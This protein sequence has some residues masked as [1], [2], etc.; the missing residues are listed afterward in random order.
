M[1]FPSLLILLLLGS[2]PMEAAAEGVPDALRKAW[3][4]RQDL[5]KTARF[6]WQSTCDERPA[7]TPQ[8][9]AN[10]STVPDLVTIRLPGVFMLDGKKCRYSTSQINLR[11]VA[12]PTEGEY[13]STFN[14]RQ[15]RHLFSGKAKSIN[16]GVV[17]SA[18]K[19]NDMGNI[20]FR[21]L[22]LCLRGL[23]ANFHGSA[24]FLSSLEVVS[25]EQV[26][27]GRQCNLLR[28]K[29]ER[30]QQDVV[31]SLAVDPAREY[32]VVQ[33]AVQVK[34]R[35]SSQ[36]DITYREDPIVGW[37][38][39]GWHVIRL[40]RNGVVASRAKSVVSDY[41]LNEPLSDELFTIEFSPGTY[42]E[43]RASGTKYLLR[44][45]G[46]QRPILAVESRRGATWEQLMATEPGKAGLR[47]DGVSR[48]TLIV[49]IG[50]FVG[51]CVVVLV[52]RRW[53]M[54]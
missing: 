46:D 8:E 24:E 15:S 53:R 9:A 48:R 33:H 49:A 10:S 1:R 17:H 21:A 41:G 31:H 22:T 39:N 5:V 47:Q 11:G 37:V 2:L 54:S 45:G 18:P 36:L 27:D 50:A 38:P 25:R 20:H 44:S 7:R 32:V 26:V 35:L 4:R 23:D 34:G 13:L 29:S 30:S 28:L 3:Q 12:D 19:Y 40:D 16:Q 52:V 42:V 14:G 51:L 43:D 6:E